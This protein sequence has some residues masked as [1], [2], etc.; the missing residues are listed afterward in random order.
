MVFRKVIPRKLFQCKLLICHWLPFLFSGLSD[1]IVLHPILPLTTFLISELLTMTEV[2]RVT[3]ITHYNAA[4]IACSHSKH[5]Q[6]DPE[7]VHLK[8]HLTQFTVPFLK[9][10]HQNCQNV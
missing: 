5:Q 7:N 8:V 2:G 9:S 3:A 6:G 1:R 4:D 10:D